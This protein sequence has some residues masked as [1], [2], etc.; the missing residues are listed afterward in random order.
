MDWKWLELCCL[1]SLGG[2][3]LQEAGPAGVTH[4]IATS[5][6]CLR[7]LSESV[8]IIFDAMQQNMTCLDC[9]NHFNAMYFFIDKHSELIL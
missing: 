6:T 3:L 7:E 1:P 8:K 9:F 4:H 2:D 5:Y